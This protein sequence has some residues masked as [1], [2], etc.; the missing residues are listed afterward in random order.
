MQESANND[1]IYE[2]QIIELK[3]NQ[4]K[5]KK[6]IYD[7][8]NRYNQMQQENEDIEELLAS[9]QISSEGQKKYLLSKLSSNKKEMHMILD[10]SP[11]FFSNL[12]EIPIKIIN[13][14]DKKVSNKKDEMQLSEE[15][16]SRD[17]IYKD[18]DEK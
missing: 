10:T 18:E 12:T 7:L 2:E 4:N 1:D 8:I 15:L 5:I 14:Y 3:D 9:D 11:E 17:Q 13:I 6:F 16:F